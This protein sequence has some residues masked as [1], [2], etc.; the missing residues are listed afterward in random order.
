MKTV[1]MIAPYFIP[2]RRVGALRPFKFAIHL[3]SYGYQPVVLTISSPDDECTELEK[4]LLKEIPILKI[5]PPFDRT[6]PRNKN[7]SSNQKEKPLLDWLDKQ[8][9]L[10]SWIY[11]FLL[12]YFEVSKKV[13]EVDPDLIWA[14]GDPW[15]GLWLG[16]KLSRSLSK[17]FIADFRDPWTVSNVN[18]RNRSAF[19]MGIDK[20]VEKRVVR[21][22][23]RVVFTSGL[24]EKKYLQEFNL[25][26]GKT[27]TIY[28][29]Y[30]LSLIQE[31]KDEKWG[32]TLNPR[33]LN[34]IFFGRFRR[35]SPVTPVAD[36]LKVLKRISLEDASNIHI[37]SFGKP[38]EENLKLIREYGLENNFLFHEPV[39]P[40][41]MVPVLKSADILLLSTNMEREQVIPAKLWDYLTVEVP[42]F[43]ITPN[44]EVSNIIM[45][46]KAGIQV[47]PDEKVEIAELLQS[48][49]KAK[50]N[51]ESFLL[52]PEKE[53]PDREKFEAKHTSG[54]LAS[55]F[56]DLLKDG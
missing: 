20:K 1:L 4:K 27:K 14:T 32:E 55:L 24:T 42:I 3:R 35:L 7:K 9:P 52:S 51:D 30:D 50:R 6:T 37:H 48:F 22:A 56:D 53:I 13:K 38:D 28:N 15:S 16:E 43:S 11:L 19:S 23:D 10:D 5:E 12:R 25:P 21:N 33:F 45:K 54:E 34:V 31:H 39:V 2:R 17:P 49:A 41:K 26:E 18:L 46:S 47:H 40:E 8:T 36:A 44:P 29:S